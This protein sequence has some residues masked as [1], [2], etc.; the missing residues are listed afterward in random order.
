[1]SPLVAGE[2]TSGKDG[3]LMGFVP[4]R[5][6]DPKPLEDC[7]CCISQRLQFGAEKNYRAR[8]L[9]SVL[10]KRHEKSHD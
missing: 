3:S 8:V 2:S 1:M 10:G 5:V 9:V 6:Q 4:H 7:K